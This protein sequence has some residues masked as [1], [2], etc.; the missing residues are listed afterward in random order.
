[1]RYFEPDALAT[2]LCA[3]VSP[4][5]HHI[6]ISSAGHLPPI[7]ARPGQP[8]AEAEVAPMCSSAS[9]ARGAAR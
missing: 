5:R 9:P 4:S 2:V 7:I 6:R 3:M 1:M 8:A